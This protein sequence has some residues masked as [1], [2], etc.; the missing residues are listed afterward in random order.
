M[1]G[2]TAAAGPFS[3]GLFYARKSHAGRRFAIPEPRSPVYWHGSGRKTVQGQ[4]NT[5]SHTHKKGP[6]FSRA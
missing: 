2:R 4:I 3:E 1:P 5:Q 6:I